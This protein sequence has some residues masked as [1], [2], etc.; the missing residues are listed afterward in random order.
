MVYSLFPDTLFFFFLSF[1]SF[2]I[3]KNT[4]LLLAPILLL[5]VGSLTERSLVLMVRA[6]DILRDQE[7]ER[8]GGSTTTALSIGYS[9]TVAHCFGPSMGTV[10]DVLIVTMNFGSGVAY[11]DVIADILAA[12]IGHPSKNV[13]LLLGTF[14]VFFWGFKYH[15]ICTMGLKLWEC[16]FHDF[17]F[18]ESL[19]H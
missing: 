5:L 8:E 9:A 18:G 17:V 1:P 3:Q 19:Y 12:W 10:A 13:G 7:S 16:S 15:L 4:G 11:L 6:G 2:L 14:T